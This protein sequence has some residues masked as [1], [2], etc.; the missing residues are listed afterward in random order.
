M[1]DTLRGR[2]ETVHADVKRFAKDA[3]RPVELLAVS[4]HQSVEAMQAYIDW[5]TEKGCTAT[6]GENYVQEYKKKQAALKGAYQV[7]FIGS[8]QKNKAR[9][10]VKLFDCIESVDSRALAEVLNGEAARISKRQAVL[11]QVNIS[12]DQA[13][14]GV[15]HTEVAG[16]VEYVLSECTSLSLRGFM[17]I[18]RYY[19]EGED[20]R[21]DFRAMYQSCERVAHAAGLNIRGLVLSM[22]M[23][24]DYS[25]A[26]QE[27]STQVRIGTALFG[28]RTMLSV[29]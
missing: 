6:F 14:H 20:A 5:C 12:L 1:S 13:K 23:S 15:P 7:H 4:K 2:F 18:T 19:E 22:G 3:A 11:V 25:V 26:I 16:L 27:G 21:H 9:D 10:A 29:T 28:E 24:A 17:C 8:L